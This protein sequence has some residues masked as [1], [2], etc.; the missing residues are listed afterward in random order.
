MRPQ[1]QTQPPR[2]GTRQLHARGRHAMLN[3]SGLYLPSV[4]SSVAILSEMSINETNLLAALIFV[5]IGFLLL[6]EMIDEVPFE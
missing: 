2:Y 1:G 3:V 6:I 5:P 4:V